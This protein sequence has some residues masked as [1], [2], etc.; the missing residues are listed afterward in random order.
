MSKYKYKGTDIANMISTG[1]SS[2][3]K[4]PGINYES[5]VNT[6]DDKLGIVKYKISGAD[7]GNTLPGKFE[8]K[9]ANNISYTAYQQFVEYP[10]GVPS[11]AN[12]VGVAAVA[13]GGGGSGGGGHAVSF[14]GIDARQP[15]GNGKK[16]GDGGTVYGN[17]DLQGAN[18]IKIR[19]G[20][21]GQYGNGGAEDSH[22]NG[23]AS[24]GWGGVGYKGGPSGVWVSPNQHLIAGGG[25]GANGGAGGHVNSGEQGSYNAAASGQSGNKGT[26]SGSSSNFMTAT[27]WNKNRV[28]NPPWSG[29][30]RTPGDGG[31][32]GN[33]GNNDYKGGNRGY[34]GV[35][36]QVYIVWKVN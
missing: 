26:S 35:N 28:Y 16:G 6:S 15:G 31:S 25:N 5:G 4:Y 32:G 17:I 19:I 29:F 14:P 8:N 12:K 24:G 7:I 21:G 9:Q 18:T 36:G 13:G 27:R 11:W 30:D 3:T 1:S 23:N 20:R 34:P 10:V 33:G 2:I 22:P